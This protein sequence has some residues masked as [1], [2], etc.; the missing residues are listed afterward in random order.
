MAAPAPR[1]SAKSARPRKP[2]PPSSSCSESSRSKLLMSLRIYDLH[3]DVVPLSIPQTN[4]PTSLKYYGARRRG[5]G[6]RHN[7]HRRLVDEA[8]WHHQRQIARRV[9]PPH[10]FACGGTLGRLEGHPDLVGRDVLQDLQQVRRVEADLERI[11]VVADGDL[12]LG[13]AEIG[14]LDGELAGAV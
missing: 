10:R 4:H 13:L 5:R 6:H 8:Q 11:A 2:P 12:L 9:V 1:A 7:S 14:R 3:A